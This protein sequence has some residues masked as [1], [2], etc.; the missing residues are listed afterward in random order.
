MTKIQ[1]TWLLLLSV[2]L[3]ACGASAS[4][5]QNTTTEYKAQKIT[6]LTPVPT[7]TVDYQQTASVAQQT[8]DEA[9]RV[10]TQ[11]TA[12]YESR[13]QEQIQFTATAEARAFAVYEWTA[14]AAMT[15]IPL[16][17][18][19]QAVKSTMAMQELAV[20]QTS[21]VMTQQ[22]P[23]MIAAMIDAE[24]ERTFAPLQS[25]V[26]LMMY[27]SMI[28]FFVGVGIFALSKAGTTRAP[29]KT[30]PDLLPIPEVSTQTPQ[31]RETV[32]NIK[33]DY[34][35]G[36][37]VSNKTVIPC[38]PEQFTEFARAVLSGEKTLAI[39]NWEEGKG[40]TL[41]GKA[42]SRVRGWLLWNKLAVSTASGQMALVE[43]GTLF[44]SEWLNAHK[45]PTEYQF[46]TG[47]SA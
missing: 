4:A 8:A 12:E 37:G 47:E 31:P 17:T 22:A 16:T 30:Y 42:Y 14:T 40:A 2:V 11:A 19:A 5:L 9:R 13:I 27:A 35:G 28:V 1:I 39:N 41:F 38:G 36:F 20:I 29:V 25:V 32:V 18:T 44:L 33:T 45:L 21:N 3:S 26:I 6:T 7:A 23:T 15:S 24:N 10:N 46:E 43:A 34:G